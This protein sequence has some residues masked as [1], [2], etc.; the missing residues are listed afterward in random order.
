MV[1]Q[2]RRQALR[3]QSAVCEVVCE[4]NSCGLKNTVV[5]IDRTVVSVYASRNVRRIANSCV[6]IKNL[7]YSWF[8]Y[9]LMDL[10][11][12]CVTIFINCFRCAL[13]AIDY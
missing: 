5:K 7:I 13:V 8:T 4:Q 2:S 12:L 11:D 9:N 6:I 10:I 1:K 3:I